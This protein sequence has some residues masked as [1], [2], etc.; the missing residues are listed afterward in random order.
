MDRLE[1][2]GADQ[3]VELGLADIEHAAQFDWCRAG[4]RPSQV[5]ERLGGVELAFEASGISHGGQD[6]AGC[7]IRIE[8]LLIG[9]CFD[10]GFDGQLVEKFQEIDVERINVMEPN[11][12][13]RMV[14]SNRARSIGPIAYNK[15]FGYP[16][17]SRPG[18]IFFNDEGTENGG[19]TFSGKTENGKFKSG[20]HFS[21][22]RFL[23]NRLREEFDFFATPLRIVERHKKK[24]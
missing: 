24:G 23:Q 18:I 22:E 15:P 4:D 9:A 1:F 3:L 13:Y 19:L 5:F 6:V 10:V 8:H 16:G 12:N 2:T 7:D 21:F 11:G 17:G 20:L 14:I